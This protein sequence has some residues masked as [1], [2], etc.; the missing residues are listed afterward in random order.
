MTREL[1]NELSL[2]VLVPCRVCVIVPT[3]GNPEE[4]AVALD[5]LGNQTFADVEIVVVGPER[6]PG[7]DVVEQRGIRYLDEGK[8]KTRADACNLCLLYTSPRTRD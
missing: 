4:L 6:D 2:G 5:G 1:I 7:R 8:S 3:V